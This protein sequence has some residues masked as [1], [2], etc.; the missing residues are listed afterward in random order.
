[1]I[2]I[3]KYFKSSILAGFLIGLAVIFSNTFASY[4]NYNKIA[5]GIIFPIGLSS[6]IIF[7]AQLFTGNIYN[8]IFETSTIKNILLL[9]KLIVCYFG[10]FLGILITVFLYINLNSETINSILN[11]ATYKVNIPINNLF[12]YGVMCN[13]VVCLIVAINKNI[14]NI[15]TK[16]LITFIILPS[17][18]YCNYEHSIANMFTLSIG[19]LYQKITIFQLLYNLSISTL[20][21]II[22]GIIIYYL[23]NKNIVE[24]R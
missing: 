4:F 17:M 11:S 7:K 9:K 23:T 24:L 12:F 5:S 6:I 2:Y 15:F 8:H 18:I 1:M 14:D 16:I 21:N 13:I 3:N 10:N 19:L 22:G 20:G